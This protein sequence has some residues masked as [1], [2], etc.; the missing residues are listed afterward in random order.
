METTYTYYDLDVWG[1]PEDGYE[2]NNWFEMGTFNASSDQEI[3]EYLTT[4]PSLC[5]VVDHAN[6]CID[7]LRK[8]DGLP[9][10]QLKY[11]Y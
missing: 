10:Y 6:G 4:D 1:N 2:I 9:L 11:N 8:E 5:E 3:L 7:I